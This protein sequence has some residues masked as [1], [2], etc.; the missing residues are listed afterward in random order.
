M[1]HEFPKEW[2]SLVQGA[3]QGRSLKSDEEQYTTH[4]GRTLWIEWT[5][6]PWYNGNQVGGAVLLVN[7]LTEQKDLFKEIEQLRYKQLLTSKMASLGEIAGG[8][9]HEINN[10]LTV[11]VGVAERLKRYALSDRVTPDFLTQQADKIQTTTDRIAQI[12]KGLKAF[13]RD[14]EQDPIISYSLNQLINESLPYLETKLNKH[15]VE[16]RWSP[17]K[18]YL[19]ECRPIQISQVIVNLINN[20][21]DAIQNLEEKWIQ[22][23]TIEEKKGIRLILSDSGKGIPQII[24]ERI[25]EPFFTTKD[26]G[27]G[28]GLGLSISKSII[29]GHNGLFFLDQKKQNTSFVIRLPFKQTERLS[30]DSGRDAISLH[31]AW[32][33]KLIDGLRTN[34]AGLTPENDP[35]NEWIQTLTNHYGD[36]FLTRGALESYEF[37]FEQTKSMFEMINSGNK[38]YV[39]SELLYSN[40]TFNSLSKIFITQIMSL[41][42]R[43]EA[44]LKK[45]S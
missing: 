5:V 13:A 21:C 4:L 10:P 6:R 38:D 33:Q 1:F 7:N 36:D 23:E 2:M 11:I 43:A 40:S 25:M 16:W 17:Q 14:S 22:L 20:A 44:S 26:I 28:T 9:A 29:E 35:L 34:F 24:A 12:I 31:L 37:L 32:K 18:D 30:V 39:S 15:N 8:V 41:E 27:K 42:Q 3:L 19:I 45:A